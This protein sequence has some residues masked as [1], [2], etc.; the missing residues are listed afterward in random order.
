MNDLQDRLR[1]QPVG[2]HRRNTMPFELVEKFPD[3][4][5][6][7]EQ[8]IVSSSYVFLILEV[9]TE[10]CI[11]GN[12]D[13][14]TALGKIVDKRFSKRIKMNAGELLRLFSTTEGEDEHDK[15]LRQSL[16]L[17]RPP[18]IIEDSDKKVFFYEL[19]RYLNQNIHN[20]IYRNSA[21]PHKSNQ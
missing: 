5:Y 8:T 11:I 18:D 6:I 19:C 2:T 12:T 13:E 14:E 4:K 9:G 1:W 17:E 15:K 21:N 3:K 10:E 7:H 16:V 20:N